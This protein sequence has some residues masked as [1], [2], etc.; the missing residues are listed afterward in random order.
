MTTPSPQQ[1]TLRMN[2]TDAL[3]ARAGKAYATAQYAEAASLYRQCTAADPTQLSAWMNLASALR[4]LGHLDASIL[5]AQRA[6]ALAPDHAGC[7]TN[8]G[9]TLIDASRID[10]GIRTQRRA[11]ALAPDDQ[12]I[13][14]N[15]AVA[16]R[17]GCLFSEALEHIDALLSQSPD[18]SS[19]QWERALC[20]LYQ[21]DYAHGWPA[22]ET[23]WKLPT[24]AAHWPQ[25][26]HW[27]GQDIAGQHL[28]VTEEQG[29][30][31]TI[32]CSRYLPVLIKRVG[33]I[34]SVTLACKKPLHPLLREIAG[35]HLTT[36]KEA[37]KTIAADIQTFDCQVTMMSL[38]GIFKTTL[39]TIPPPA[40]LRAAD[41][42]LPAIRTALNAA[43]NRLKVG[44]VW[45][46]SV[47]FGN[48]RKRATT[49]A[50]FAAL[51]AIPNVE[52]Y[53]LQK[54]PRETDLRASGMTAII[55]EIGPM[56]NDFSETAAVLRELD[57][58]IMTD[59]SVAHLAGS[60][61][62]PVWNL[63]HDCPYWLY[64][65][66]RNDSP[67]Y[68]SMRLYRQNTPGDWDELFSRVIDDLKQVASIS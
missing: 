28:L 42:L 48:N 58:V 3:F 47:T 38:P 8:L 1:H 59:S 54:G 41:N 53:S 10:E 35:L 7:L 24:M 49:A 37:D 43:G 45:S 22:F 52:I 6:S 19:L 16:L 23:R 11:H 66:E 30:G 25:I 4:R 34:G 67:W 26:P 62:V 18:E 46:G 68:P 21:G 51:A 12:L 36:M 39:D 20:L 13:R 61:N 60:L 5:A 40:P 55:H 65:H 32:L 50:R 31:D 56:L 2:S 9:N 64:L 57:L 15:L 33:A 44:I 29:F 27:Q 63:L 14:R 17:E